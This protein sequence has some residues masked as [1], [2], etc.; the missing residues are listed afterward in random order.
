LFVTL[1]INGG[2]P[3]AISAGK[4][5]RTAAS[6]RVDHPATKPAPVSRTMVP[7]LRSISARW[8]QEERVAVGIGITTL[9]APMS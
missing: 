5:Q 7:A 3:T 9:L 8:R 1:A 4:T 6:G 2:H